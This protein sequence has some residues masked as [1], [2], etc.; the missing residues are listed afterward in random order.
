MEKKRIACIDV[1]SIIYKASAEKIQY[2]QDGNPQI[3][4]FGNKVKSE[5]T[6]QECKDIL[7]DLIVDILNKTEAT[8]Y[9][10]ALTTGKCHRYDFYPEYKANRKDKEK[11]KHFHSLKDYCV[12]KHKA[13]FH[14]ELE[15]DDICVIYAKAL[16]KDE[17]YAYICSIDKDLLNLEGTHFNY[18]KSSWVTV[19]K[20][21]ASYKFW[22]D[23]IVGQSGD[24][25]KGIPGR[26]EKFAAACLEN[27][28]DAGHTNQSITLINYIEKFGEDL[29]IREFYKNY[30]CLK[31]K[32]TWPNFKIEEPIKYERF[33][34]SN[35]NLNDV[36]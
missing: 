25:I 9:I 1:D 34:T 2:D 30:Q 35:I 33:S 7:D 36:Y 15:A 23:M 12:T 22:F 14:H 29:G 6:L 21:E 17:D 19:N 10:L 13:I 3:D 20:E 8:H 5:M 26:G 11:P 4:D 27:V 18:D 31:I 24:N 16:T 28:M 32:D